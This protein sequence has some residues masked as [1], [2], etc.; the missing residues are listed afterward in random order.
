MVS[1]GM[2]TDNHKTEFKEGLI[3]HD[4]KDP[5]LL[6]SLLRNKNNYEIESFWNFFFDNPDNIPPIPNEFDS[7]KTTYPKA[8]LLME[9]VYMGKFKKKGN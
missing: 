2:H 9:N 7:I 1:S 4:I 3:N 8:Y 5:I 6:F